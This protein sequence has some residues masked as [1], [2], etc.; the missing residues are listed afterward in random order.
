MQS[1]VLKYS[2]TRTFVQSLICIIIHNIVSVDGLI[3]DP[4]Y[5]PNNITRLK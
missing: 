5:V 1:A 2:S 3:R 4:F